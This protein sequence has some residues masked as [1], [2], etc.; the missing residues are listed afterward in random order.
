MNPTGPLESWAVIAWVV[1][2][3]SSPFVLLWLLSKMEDR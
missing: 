1:I 2:C 3:A